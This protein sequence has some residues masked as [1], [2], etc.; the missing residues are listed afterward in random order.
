[1]IAVLLTACTIIGWLIPVAMFMMLVSFTM[2]EYLAKKE[3][4][5]FSSFSYAW[6]LITQ[7]SKIWHAS[8]CVA[9]VI[10]IMTIIQQIISGGIQLSFGLQTQ[11]E[12]N[13]TEVDFG[14]EYWTAMVIL[15]LAGILIQLI[16]NVVTYL[17]M[18][19]T[20]YSLKAE[21]EN[22]SSENTIDEI[23]RDI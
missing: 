3:N 4:R 9:V 7:K 1:M 15:S 19:I 23:G 21:K 2:Y 12:I 6:D 22:I 18:G 5:F 8:G 17:N 16:T 10:L 13:G 11:P 14:A 20:F